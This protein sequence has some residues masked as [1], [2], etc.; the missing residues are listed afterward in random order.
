MIKYIVY[1]IFYG[2]NST[3]ISP[4]SQREIALVISHNSKCM[5]LRCLRAVKSRIG[6]LDD[7]VRIVKVL[8]TVNVA[9]GFDDT[10]SVIHGCSDF[11]REVFGPAG[12]HAR[13][14]VSM[15]IPENFA[16]EVE[17]VVEVN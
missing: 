16:V 17:M 9:P 12:Y 11:L 1:S 8:G 4:F 5:S 2:C 7:I 14:A 3:N 6:S 13:S 10:P 15:T